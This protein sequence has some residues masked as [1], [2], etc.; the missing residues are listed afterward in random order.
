VHLLVIGNKNKVLGLKIGYDHFDHMIHR[1]PIS[2]CLLKLDIFV[3]QI[4]KMKGVEKNGCKQQAMCYIC[5]FGQLLIMWPNFSQ[6]K[7]NL[8]I[9]HHFFSYS[10]SG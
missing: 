9:V 2:H 10:M 7:H 3:C 8:F 1:G 5:F 6:Y 4:F